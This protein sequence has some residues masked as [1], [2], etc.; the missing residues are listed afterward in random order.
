MPRIPQPSTV[1]TNGDFLRVRYRD[2]EEFETLR[3]PEWARKTAESVV[4]GSEL[5]RGKQAG[6]ENWIRQEVLIPEPVDSTDAGRKA[7]EILQRIEY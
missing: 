7:N 1:E 2:P 6:G 3:T 4:D 5:W